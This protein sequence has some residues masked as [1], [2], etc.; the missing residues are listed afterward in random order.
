MKEFVHSAAN[1]SFFTD[2]LFRSRPTA[3]IRRPICFN[4]NSYSSDWNKSVL[5]PFIDRRFRRVTSDAKTKQSLPFIWCPQ[6]K[7]AT[8][9]P[10][11][12]LLSPFKTCIT[13]KLFILFIFDYV[14][15]VSIHRSFHQN[16]NRPFHF[17]STRQSMSTIKIYC[18]WNQVHI[19]C[20]MVMENGNKSGLWLRFIYFWQITVQANGF[21]KPT[22]TCFQ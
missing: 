21:V 20:F 19:S 16:S 13:C 17:Y 10:I 12:L 3:R 15:R 1:F 6:Y 11:W 14:Y 22:K 8:I 2:K 4:Q 18:W 9:W 5:I 7:G